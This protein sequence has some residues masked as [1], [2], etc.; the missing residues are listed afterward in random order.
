[1]QG[2][3]VVVNDKSENESTN[4]EKTAEIDRNV[5]QCSEQAGASA[6]SQQTRP[7]GKEGWVTFGTMIKA[8]AV[9]SILTSSLSLLVYDRLF[10]TK[11]MAYDLPGFN[12]RCRDD[13][14]TGKI[15][16]EQYEERLD[17]LD[18]GVNGVPRNTVV[19]TGDV[20]LG[21]HAKRLAIPG[22]PDIR[23]SRQKVQQQTNQP[24]VGQPGVMQQ[25]IPQGQEQ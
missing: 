7:M 19:I 23:E 5:S 16:L 4:G 2:E 14:L 24:Q 8:I 25:M 18:V 9:V 12:D 21:K 6:G 17:A 11:I 20:V 10:A 1:M 3:E 15:T 13:L 22:A